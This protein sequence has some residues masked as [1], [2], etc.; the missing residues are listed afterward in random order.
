MR[1]EQYNPSVQTWINRARRAQRLVSQ[2]DLE[3]IVNHDA[4]E[5]EKLIKV[6]RAMDLLCNEV[7]KPIA[8]VDVGEETPTVDKHQQKRSE[9][10]KALDGAGYGHGLGRIYMA[11]FDDP[12]RPLDLIPHQQGLPAFDV[13]VAPEHSPPDGA[14]GIFISEQGIFAAFI[15]E[16]ATRNKWRILR[17]RPYD[18]LDELLTTVR[19]FAAPPTE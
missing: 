8:A 13:C 7:D 10:L 2:V 5:F 6:S 11:N 15:P 14:Q 1:D 16:P 4:A 18:D 17:S 9:L 3:R 19:R 12:I